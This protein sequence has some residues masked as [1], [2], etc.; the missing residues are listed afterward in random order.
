VK[1]FVVDDIRFTILILIIAAF[2]G[3]ILFSSGFESL[4]FRS[5]SGVTQ[6]VGGWGP[7]GLVAQYFGRPMP[8]FL[9]LFSIYKIRIDSKITAKSCLFL[10][11]SLCLT[12][13]LNFPIGVARFYAFTVYL[14]II[15]S[16]F[17]PSGGKAYFYLAVLL[18][19]L[20]GASIVDAFRY[21]T[22][23]SDAN[24]NLGFNTKTFFVG[25]F[26]AYEN[27]M[28]S[29]EY[30]EVH[31]VAMGRQLVGTIF[32][33]IPRSIWLDKPVSTGT[34]IA[35][36]YLQ[37]SHKVY[38]H[39]VSSPYIEELYIDFHIPA[40]IIGSFL[41][42]FLF[43]YLDKTYK[44]HR[45]LIETHFSAS[46]LATSPK[47]SY[48]VLYPVFIGLSFLL[49]RGAA[50]TAFA[51]TCGVILSYV[52]VRLLLVKPIFRTNQTG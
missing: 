39:N 23:F 27:F 43:A 40:V 1:L 7:L 10:L 41:I 21:A 2:S 45:E 17:R 16:I 5:R 49:L 8:L 18:V 48:I 11:I 22:S 36:N 50:L 33:W 15:I 34:Y 35:Q 28:H 3:F 29:I 44:M 9:L 19:G 20:V 32:F 30:V 4:L 51:Y 6:A 38:N 42:G 13:L 26:D 47:P 25:H 12:L 46:H 14:S 37:L 24:I 52:F 31:G